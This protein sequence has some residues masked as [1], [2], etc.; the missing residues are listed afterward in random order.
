MALLGIS[1]VSPQRQQQAVVQQD[2]PSDFEKLMMGLQAAQSAFGIAADYTRIG[3]IQQQQEIAGAQEQRAQ[4][5]F[6]LV[7]AQ[8]QAQT[9]GIEAQ[10]GL[11]QAQTQEIQGR[12]EREAQQFERQMQADQI[13]RQREAT[14]GLE[15]EILSFVDS[16]P[17]QDLIT[18]LQQTNM[19]E[20][21]L[22]LETPQADAQ[23]V[24]QAT[25]ALAGESGVLTDKDIDRNIGLMGLDERMGAA[26]R[27]WITGGGQL[28]PDM[29]A[30]IRE[31][32]ALARTR[33]QG[34][35]AN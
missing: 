31:S 30:N 28:S 32:T 24:T 29:R 6:P 10:T 33:I 2:G 20:A 27:K 13:K 17:S 12:P 14:T 11:R 19:I 18:N 16:K 34:Q 22:S 9:A 26:F 1:P 15:T 4:Q 21:L 23:A 7:Q 25:R 8:Q 5:Q 35:M 3:Q